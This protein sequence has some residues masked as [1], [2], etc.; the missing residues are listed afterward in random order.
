MSTERISFDKELLREHIET[1][2]KGVAVY[3]RIYNNG[4][5]DGFGDFGNAVHANMDIHHANMRINSIVGDIKL[6]H[7]S[8]R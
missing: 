2:K 3:E 6:N 4:Y 8:N 7:I 1:L 5:F